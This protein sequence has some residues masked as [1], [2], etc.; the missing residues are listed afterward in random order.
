ML[1]SGAILMQTYIKIDS[2]QNKW[3]IISGIIT[4][5]IPSSNY[6]LGF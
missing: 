1:L 6:C 2:L 3:I 4:S 5:I